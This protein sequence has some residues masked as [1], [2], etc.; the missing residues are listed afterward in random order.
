MEGVK[1]DIYKNIEKK[2]GYNNERNAKVGQNI[3]EKNRLQFSLSR[4]LKNT[5]Y[6]TFCTV[7]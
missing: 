7:H 6:S 4:I 1:I 2:C 3:I 5:I